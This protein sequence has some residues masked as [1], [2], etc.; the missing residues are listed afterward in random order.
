MSVTTLVTTKRLKRGDN[1]YLRY[2]TPKRIQALG[3]PREVV[4]SHQRESAWEFLSDHTDHICDVYA[5][6]VYSLRF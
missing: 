6:W 5:A 4:K 2:R 3:F 1:Y